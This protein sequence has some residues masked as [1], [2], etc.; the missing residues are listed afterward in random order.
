MISIVLNVSFSID[1]MTEE[2]VQRVRSFAESIGARVNLPRSSP[3]NSANGT[4]EERQAR[5][6]Y[7]ADFGETFRPTKNQFARIDAG[8]L[9]ILEAIEETRKIKALRP[10][11]PHGGSIPDTESMPEGPSVDSLDSEDL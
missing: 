4:A 2:N 10:T 9:T 7:K 11:K 6:A 1:D 8:E 5:D 3:I